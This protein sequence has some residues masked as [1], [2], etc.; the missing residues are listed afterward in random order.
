MIKNNPA[1]RGGAILDER[2]EFI[3]MVD[4]DICH[5]Q[6]VWKQYS[7]DREK[8]EELFHSMLFKYIEKIEFLS[9]GLNVMTSYEDNNKM[10]D[11]YRSNV[12]ALIRRLMDF[13]ENGYTNIGILDKDGHCVGY[14]NQLTMSFNQCRKEIGEMEALSLIDKHKILNKIDNM[15][16]ILRKPKTRREKWELLRPYIFWLSGKDVDVAIKLLPLFLNI[17]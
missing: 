13:R 11:A 14:E 7:H 3:K 2:E 10:A 5:C 8:M 4:E 16:E 15:E 17:R 6:E 1:K 9:Q 12:K